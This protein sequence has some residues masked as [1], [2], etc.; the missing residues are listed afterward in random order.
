MNV[1]AYRQFFS[2]T[3]VKILLVVIFIISVNLLSGYIAV[4]L[5]FP[6]LWGTSKIFFEYAF[7]LNL[8]WGLAHIPS[9][10]LL[11]IPLFL[12][13]GWN[14]GQIQ[15]F[16]ISCVCLFLLL[17]YGVMEK[18]PFALYPAVDLFVAFFFS[19]II[20]P[21]NY[22]ENPKLTIALLVLLSI[23]ILTSLIIGFSKWQHRTP[24]IKETNLMGGLFILLNI[25]AGN[26]YRTELTFTVELTKFIDQKTVCDTASEMGE[27]LFKRYPFDNDYKK[28]IKVLF[29]PHQKNM[30]PYTLGE[31]GQF[32]ENGK[33]NIACY[34]QYR[35]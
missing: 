24:T 30:Q 3:P 28:I 9:F 18:V 16:R 19:L 34:L 10:L 20:V 17:L 13:P 4:W 31:I 15:R 25:D 27:Q 33:L 11:S 22:K 21:P 14:Q 7:P 26:N 2:K 1:Q 8:N 35:Q 12:L 29:N 5:R 6:S 32:R 23:V